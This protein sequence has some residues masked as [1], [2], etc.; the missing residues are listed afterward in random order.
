[1]TTTAIII[2]SVLLGGSVCLNIA[3]STTRKHLRARVKRLKGDISSLEEERENPFVKFCTAS[4][5]LGTWYVYGV[6]S[7]GGYTLIKTFDTKDEE[8]NYNEAVELVENLERT[9]CYD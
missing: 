1:M 4:Y 5:G 8:Y 9:L 7:Q 6:G 3:A 2:L